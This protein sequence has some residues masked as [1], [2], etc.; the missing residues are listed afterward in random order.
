[1]QPYVTV[2]NSA[3]IRSGLY[4]YFSLKFSEVNMSNYTKN[5]RFIKLNSN[6]NNNNKRK[7]QQISRNHS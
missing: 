4:C 5:V 1:M 6:K 3:E 2:V 7:P